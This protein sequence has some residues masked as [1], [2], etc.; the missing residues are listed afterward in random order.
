MPSDRLS[1][2]REMIADAIDWSRRYTWASRAPRSA[3]AMR[4]CDGEAMLCLVDA[5]KALD[6]VT[7]PGD[8]VDQLRA[9]INELRGM[10]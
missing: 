7:E 10:E 2:V 8:D 5:E 9:V 3:L 4:M 6:D 1:H